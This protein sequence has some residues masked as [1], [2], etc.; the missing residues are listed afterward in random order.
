MAP[1][2]MATVVIVATGAGAV[3]VVAAVVVAALVLVAAVAK[4]TNGSQTPL[5]SP[6]L[7]SMSSIAGRVTRA[8]CGRRR[9]RRRVVPWPQLL[10]LMGSAGV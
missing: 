5:V 10:P 3:A 9:R 4:V 1:F 6:P 8:E 7:P 2:G